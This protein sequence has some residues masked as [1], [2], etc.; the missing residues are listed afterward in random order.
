MQ[1][2]GKGTKILIE[3]DNIVPG[4]NFS[5]IFSRKNKKYATIPN[6]SILAI[7][8]S[9]IPSRTAI[10][11]RIKEG[12]TKYYA[13]VEYPDSDSSELL[14]FIG[15]VEGNPLEIS[16]LKVEHYICPKCGEKVI[17]SDHPFCGNC[18]YHGG[19][20]YM[21]EVVWKP[22]LSWEEAVKGALTRK[23]LNII[24]EEEGGKFLERLLAMRG[25]TW[26]SIN[27]AIDTLGAVMK[28]ELERVE[29]ELSG[30]N[31]RFIIGQGYMNI[32]GKRE[33]PGR[34][35]VL[36]VGGTIYYTRL[37]SIFSGK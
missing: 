25:Y 37:F 17:K 32:D 10:Q 31:W 1:K 24:E 12:G 30:P 5:L 4:R 27:T 14:E 2:V 18:G 34:F 23:D 28:P 36:Q 35:A 16:E 19:Y 6:A 11:G 33:T 26:I 22:K 8:V 29:E 7:I 13:V 20:K 21:T 3:F 15:K 9:A